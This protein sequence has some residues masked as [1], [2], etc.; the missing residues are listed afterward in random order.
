M[1]SKG[2][3]G[4]RLIDADAITYESIDSSDTGRQWQYHGTGIIAVRKKDIDKMDTIHPE[5]VR[6]KD[7]KHKPN[8]NAAEHDVIFPDDK[9]PCQCEDYWYSWIPRDDWYC[10]N[11]ERKEGNE[12]SE[13]M[14]KPDYEQ[15]CKEYECKIDEFNKQIKELQEKNG[16]MN[17]EIEFKSNYIARLE[18]YIQ[19]LEFAIRC[20]GVSGAE[21]KFWE[22]RS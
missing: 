11:A 17:D 15:L 18:G 20:N 7:C 2:G 6:C 3:D 8:G 10:G 21:V 14:T 9:C 4:M 16:C 1:E 5:I 22:D 12:I 19:G 13:D